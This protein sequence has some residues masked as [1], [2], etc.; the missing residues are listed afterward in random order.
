[1]S[2]AQ[3]KSPIP[4]RRSARVARPREVRVGLPPG[5]R[6]P[7]GF[8]SLAWQFWP[9]PFLDRCRARYGDIFTVTVAPRAAA[10]TQATWVML[11]DPDHVKQ[12]FTGDAHSLRAGEANRQIPTMARTVGERSILLLDEPE[13]TAQR[14][15]MSPAF[16]GARVQ[17]YAEVMSRVALAEVD[18]WPVGEPF[19]LW[20]R[21]Q[22]VTLEIIVRAVF[23]VTDGERLDHMRDALRRMLNGGT[24]AWRQA[25]LMILGE[26]GT[27]RAYNAI[28][29]PVDRALL[30]AIQ[31]R[32][33]TGD[34][35]ARGDVLSML[36]TAR[37]DDGSPLSDHELRDELM[38]LLIA[39]HE[40]TA[41]AI[42]WAFDGLLRHRDMV[43][44]LRREA[45]TGGHAYAD[46]VVKES[47][48]LW[49]VLPFVARRLSEP[50]DVGRF[51]L[52]AGIW[53]APC[54]YLIH[55]REDV[56]PDAATFH[57][58]RFL[59]EPPGT[60]TWIPFGGGVRR[61]L[62]ASFA[63]LEMRQVLQTVIAHADLR[64]TSTRPQRVRR[65]YLT[66]TPARGGRVS[67]LRRLDPPTGA[68]CA[69]S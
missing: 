18:R 63:Q 19:A 16:H 69:V 62:G 26:R 36:V 8:Q 40:S 52:P 64:P 55:R 20:P 7:G 38:T 49:P 67:L 34:V 51:L 46:A 66:L 44:R 61:C 10:T 39:G 30:D 41:S 3:A 56:Y 24:S 31:Q 23:G 33:A 4:T 29:D 12:V 58:E 6:M 11:A 54:A 48:R 47:L 21:M 59:E 17:N 37:H 15:L 45:V 35:D 50:T 14:R 5:P 13:H 42:T 9:G 68:E 43:D 57:P 2:V 32:R 28:V 65:R 60:Y 25:A 1:M 27:G 22:A 53:V